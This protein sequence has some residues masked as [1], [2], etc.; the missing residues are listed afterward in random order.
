MFQM[1]INTVKNKSNKA[2]LGE[3]FLRVNAITMVHEMLYNKDE[4]EYV[5]VKDYLNELIAKL[6]EVV[7]D[8][9]IPVQFHLNVDQ[10]TF[11]INHCVAIGMIT[12]EIINNAIKYA[13]DGILNPIINISLSYN[14]TEEMI[15]YII[16]DN[17]VGLNKKRATQGLGMRLIDIFSRQIEMTYELKNENGL[18]YIFKI[19][20][21]KNEK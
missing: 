1:Q 4:L 14:R 17:G 5:M 10:V 2:V 16:K 12:S 8:K 21:V 15:T 7:C 6:N 11:D 20:F 3:A 19:P 13:F 9:H 18:V